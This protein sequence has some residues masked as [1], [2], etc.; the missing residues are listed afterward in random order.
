MNFDIV[1]NRTIDAKGKKTVLIKSTGHEKSSFTVV[2]TC[3]ADRTK[4]KPMIIFKRK[5]MPKLKF[6]AGVY[7]HVHEKCW[8]DEEGVKL[9][10]ENVWNRRPGGNGKDRS[11]LVWDMFR[12]HLT[13]ATKKRL[14]RIK[15]DQAVIPGGLTSLVQP[16]D[17][18]LNKPFKDRVRKEWNNWMVSG[19]KAFTKG[20]NM[21]PPQLDELANFVLKAWED[22]ETNMVVR[23]FKKRGVSNAMDGTEDDYRICLR[24]TQQKLKMKR[25]PTTLLIHMTTA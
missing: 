7:I 17:V 22:T 6:P 20:G 16:L 25:K 9:W 14:A 21:R 15:T 2:L 4:L 23:S 12:S 11:M 19:E 3:M 8:M 24:M 1:G 18:C 10:L 13:P 5:T